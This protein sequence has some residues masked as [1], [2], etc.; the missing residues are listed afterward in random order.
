M[1][2]LHRIIDVILFSC[3][4]GIS[5]RRDTDAV[6][7][8]NNGNFLGIIELI[9]HYDPVLREHVSKVHEFQKKGNVYRLIIFLTIHKMNSFIYVQISFVV[10]G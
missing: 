5:F 1:E 3:Q 7:D 9:S 4:R 8:V 6:G 2:L 10:L